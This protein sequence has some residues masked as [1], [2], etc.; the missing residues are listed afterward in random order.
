[1]WTA[2]GFVW[3]RQ[4]REHQAKDFRLPASFLVPIPNKGSS[5]RSVRVPWRV[6]VSLRANL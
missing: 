1:V 6:Q 3:A 4:S 5:K 2:A